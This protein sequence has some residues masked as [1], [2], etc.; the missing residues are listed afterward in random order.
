MASSIE[1]YS[2]PS[3]ADFVLTRAE[4]VTHASPITASVKYLIVELEEPV[5]RRLAIED[6]AGHVQLMEGAVSL[7]GFSLAVQE[8]LSQHQHE[9]R[10]LG[11]SHALMPALTLGPVP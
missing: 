2:L 5:A 4:S 10:A 1:G 9:A 3:H 7:K 6:A 11:W 8:V